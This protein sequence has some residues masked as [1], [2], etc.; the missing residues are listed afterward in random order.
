MCYVGDKVACGQVEE[1]FDSEGR[2]IRSQQHSADDIDASSRDELLGHL[3]NIVKTHN[4]DHYTKVLKI[5][6]TNKLCDS[7][8][9]N[10]CA[11]TPGMWAVVG[12]VAK[13]L[14][15]PVPIKA[16]VSD[17]GDQHTLLLQAKTAPVGY[18]LHLIAINLLLR[19][20]VGAWTNLSFETAKVLAERAPDNELFQW[21]AGNTEVAKALLMKHGETVKEG[22]DW[23]VSQGTAPGHPSCRS[24]L[25]RLFSLKI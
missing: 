20:H 19:L 16:T 25:A 7:S 12:L 23:W 15:Q 3:L 21:L 1:L 4:L 5:V 11:M 9:D 13:H 8:S 24:F 17:L 18:Q 14:G 10:R 22:G 2:F 6:N